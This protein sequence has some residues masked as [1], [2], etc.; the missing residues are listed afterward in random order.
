MDVD[1]DADADVERLAI[2]N[3]K[4]RHPVSESAPGAH[5]PITVTGTDLFVLLP[6]PS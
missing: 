4:T 5:S 3:R 1:A 2:V 6:L